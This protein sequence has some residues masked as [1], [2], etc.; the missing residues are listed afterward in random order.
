MIL[1][2][3]GATVAVLVAA[4]VI[5]R[6]IEPEDTAD[7]IVVVATLTSGTCV[8]LA[9]LAGSAGALDPAVLLIGSIGWCVVTVVMIR[10]RLPDLSMLAKLRALPLAARSAPW[11]TALVLLAT[12]A[13][14]WQVLVAIVLPP[15]AFDGISYHLT[16]VSDWVQSGELTRSDLSLCCASYPLGADLL[17]AWVVALDGGTGLVDLVQVPHVV[18]ASAAVAGLGRSAGLRPS[19]ALAAAAIFAVTPIVLVQAPTNMVDVIVTSWTLAGLHWLV[20]FAVTGDRR[21]LLLVALVAGLV[22]GT[23]GTGVLW[24]TALVAAA[25][26]CLAWR[27]HR[28]VR[29]RTGVVRIGA[30]VL[31]V[32]AAVGAPWYLRNWIEE[33]NPLH[34]FAVSV[35]GVA[36]FDGP[37]EVD[38]VLTDPPGGPEEH[39]VESVVRSWASDLRF[40][41]QGSY[42][43]QQRSGGLGPVFVWFGVPAGVV[44][45]AV[46]LRR[47]SPPMWAV[48]VVTAVFAIQPYRWW[49]RFTIPFAALGAVA[50]VVV[51]TELPQWPRRLLRAGVLVTALAG[52]ALS[53]YEVDPAARAEPLTAQD[54]VALVGASGSERDLGAVFHPEYRFVRDLPTEARVLVDLGADE[55]RFVSPLFG[56]RLTRVVEPLAEDRVPGDAWVVTGSSRSVT[57]TLRGDPRFTVFAEE[58]GITVFAPAGNG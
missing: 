35:A 23:K 27:S 41:A 10:P 4:A 43:Y 51:S 11:T 50:I 12:G 52:V 33:G 36:V 7:Q 30:A 49:S 5:G 14:A 46:G 38:G 13:L 57:R 22:L 3:L 18:L 48:G 15:F 8:G 58:H 9:G 45:V 31:L 17:F 54:L 34:P 56:D 40:W 53:S 47:R 28:A 32:V 29:E 16:I 21:R 2:L 6:W 42:D 39:A 37:L 19:G 20:R 26:G 1:G 55:V 25:L 24:G 44:A